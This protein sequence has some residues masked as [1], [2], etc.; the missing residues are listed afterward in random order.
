[1]N[2]QYL[3]I[4]V[5][6]FELIAH[7]CRVFIRKPPVL[8]AIFAVIFTPSLLQ[9]KPDKPTGS[10]TKD[11]IALVMD[12]KTVFKD[13]ISINTVRGIGN[14]GNV[15]SKSFDKSK[16][17]GGLPGLKVIAPSKVS[18]YAAEDKESQEIFDTQLF[19]LIFMVFVFYPILF[20]PYDQ[21]QYKP[22]YDQKQYKPMKPNV[23]LCGRPAHPFA[24]PRRWRPVR[25]SYRLDPL[26]L[27]VDQVSQ[28]GTSERQSLGITKAR[29]HAVP[30]VVD[31]R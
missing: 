18:T 6:V 29:E 5:G 12:S 8:F 1:M 4:F 2:S 22:M 15:G 24:A 7:K 30:V 23:V 13:G 20:F 9:A 11:N 19:T 28:S 16:S 21:K 31:A 27:V 10:S 3:C 26:P 17:G 14:S 25:T